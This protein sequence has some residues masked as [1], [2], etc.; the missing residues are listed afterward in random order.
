MT[1]PRVQRSF[2]RGL[3]S[4]HHAASPQAAI[5]EHLASLLADHAPRDLGQIF[6]FGCGTGHFTNALTARFRSTALYLNDLVEDCETMIP[7]GSRFSPGPVEDISLPEGLSMIASASTIQ[8]VHDVP[9]LMS[10]LWNHLAPGGWL[11]L[12]GFGQDHFHQLSSLGSTASAPG[13][14]DPKA[15][16]QMLP[17][18]AVVHHLSKQEITV[19]FTSAM[20]LLRHLRQTGVNGQAKGGW[21]RARLTRFEAEYFEKFGDDG[22]IP[23]TYSPV[24]LIARKPG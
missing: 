12:S 20:E 17:P 14:V 4:Y 1:N 22:Q 21:S 2:Q 11:A 10:K 19:R 5:A 24:Y 18:E 9:A 7:A 15:W 8:W 16:A 6:E 13:Y 23:L 3:S